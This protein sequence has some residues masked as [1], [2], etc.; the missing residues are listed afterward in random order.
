MENCNGG[1]LLEFFKLRNWQVEPEAIHKIMRQVVQGFTDYLNELLVHRDLSMKN[2]MIHFP[3]K[4]KD[5]LARN[6][7]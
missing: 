3:D 7:E 5:M 2:I 1:S 6:N 4:T